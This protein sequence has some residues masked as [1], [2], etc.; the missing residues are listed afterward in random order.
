MNIMEEIFE[1][2]SWIE[3]LAN[4]IK[5]DTTDQFNNVLCY[6]MFYNEELQGIHNKSFS[7]FKT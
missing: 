4:G 5:I 1:I 6:V 3:I 7:S 2:R